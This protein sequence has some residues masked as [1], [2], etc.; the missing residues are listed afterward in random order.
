MP[1]VKTE[2]SSHISAPLEYA[3]G[4]DRSILHGDGGGMSSAKP[5]VK[6]TLLPRK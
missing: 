1:S 5:T 2:T 3:K 6:A 4:P